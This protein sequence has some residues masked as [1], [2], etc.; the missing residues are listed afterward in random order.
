MVPRGVGRGGVTMW[1][2]LDL[3]VAAAA[4]RV[5][6]DIAAASDGKLS[7]EVVRRLR[8]LPAML[9][10]SGVPATI[11]FAEARARSGGDLG[12]AYEEVAKALRAQL[13][14]ELGWPAQP[15][16]LY[17]TMREASAA[18]LACGFVR[19]DA[20]AGWLRRLAEAAPRVEKP[21]KAGGGRQAGSDA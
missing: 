2:R 18:D 19:L 21:P 15:A 8:G 13:A 7:D 17:A 9:R 1:K 4:E 14:A 6:S 3:D 12:K 20:F 16:Q 5:V 11:A 10:V